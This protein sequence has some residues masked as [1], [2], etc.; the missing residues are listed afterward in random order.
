MTSVISPSTLLLLGL[1]PG[2]GRAGVVVTAVDPEVSTLEGVLLLWWLVRVLGTM[3][4]L[5]TSIVHVTTR[6]DESGPLLSLLPLMG[7]LIPVPWWVLK[8]PQL[9][10]FLVSPGG[11]LL[12]VTLAT[13]VLPV[14]GS[15]ATSLC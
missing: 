14:C 5:I 7:P 8:E 15:G 1:G 4:C 12:V 11:L 3:A 2:L 10:S 9:T 13:R 6:R